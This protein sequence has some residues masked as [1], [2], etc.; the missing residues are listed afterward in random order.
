VFKIASQQYEVTGTVLS[1]VICPTGIASVLLA[2][3]YLGNQLKEDEKG[4]ACDVWG[5]RD[6][7]VA[8]WL[9]NLKER[10]CMEDLCVEG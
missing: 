6:M 3:Y 7:Q 1:H 5:R 4:G 2:R 10:D 8:F 9:G